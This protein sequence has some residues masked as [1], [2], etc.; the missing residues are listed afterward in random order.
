MLDGPGGRRL[1]LPPVRQIVVKLRQEAP[2]L[3]QTRVIPEL[4]EDLDG[5]LRLCQ[6]RLPVADRVPRASDPGALDPRVPL[7]PSVAGPGGRLHGLGEHVDRSSQ[8]SHIG[9]GGSQIRQHARP[10]AIVRQ[11][12]LGC[13]AQEADGRRHVPPLVGTPAGRGEMS[14]RTA[15]K[16]L[17]G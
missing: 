1:H 17:G 4:L 12:Q 11:Q 9:E 7:E 16:C 3:G 5:L 15:G 13:T 14:G 10:G 6:E 2:G 8:F